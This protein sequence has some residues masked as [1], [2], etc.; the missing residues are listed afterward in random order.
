MTMGH[1]IMVGPTHLFFR[2][3]R[4]LSPCAEQFSLRPNGG[5]SEDEHVVNL[6]LRQKPYGGKERIASLISN[7]VFRLPG[8]LVFAEDQSDVKV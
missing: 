4:L 7:L 1:E 8:P 5:N 2:A 3:I 6:E